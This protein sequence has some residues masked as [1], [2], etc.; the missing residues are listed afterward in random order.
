MVA[1]PKQRGQYPMF[2]F[3]DGKCSDFD[4]ENLSLEQDRYLRVRHLDESG[5]LQSTTESEDFVVL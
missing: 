4:L 1:P 2:I 5:H 3:S